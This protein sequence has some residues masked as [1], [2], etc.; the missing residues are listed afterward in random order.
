MFNL[1][2]YTIKGKLCFIETY[3][4]HDRLS[5]NTKMYYLVKFF[6]GMIEK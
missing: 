6:L 1:D 4:K 3:L 5:C 2:K